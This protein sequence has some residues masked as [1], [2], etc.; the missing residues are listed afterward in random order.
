MDERIWKVV[1]SWN[2]WK[3]GPETGVPREVV[4][5]AWPFTKG[6]EAVY[7]YGPRRAGK[8]FV[9]YQILDKLSKKFGRKSCLYINFE[10][11]SFSTRLN[12][13][14]ITDIVECFTTVFGRKPK[15]IFLDE[16]QNVP[17]WEK[18]VRATV[19]KKEYK[20]FVTGS[21]AKLLSTE[22]STSLGGRGVGF[23][24]LPFSYREFR[25]A[26]PGAGFEDYLE[27]G[28]YPAV[29]L[30]ADKRKRTRL[31]E[32]YFETAIARDITG[33]Y[34]VRDVQTLKTLAVYTLTNSGK[35]FSYNKL[36]GMTGLSF[37]ALRDYLSYLEGAFMVFSAPSFSYSLKKAMQKP[38]KY[39]AYDVG[40]KSAV[41]KS[42]SRDFGRNAENSVAIELVRRGWE[43]QYYSNDYEVDFVVKEGLQLRAINVSYA[44]HP[45][46]R[47]RSSLEKF[48]SEHSMSSTLLLDKKGLEE[49]MLRTIP[50]P[51]S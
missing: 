41:S 50:F 22:F 10:E 19:D 17:Q 32:E 26:R 30:E 40:L 1:E 25:V 44:G 36:R 34:D 48:R 27:M 14:F 21:S 8:T 9:C 12:T 51:Y 33:R 28:G 37:D 15:F 4:K 24:V 2:F 13:R 3:E 16:V 35:L 43:P 20:V 46:P 5:Q 18:W 42:Y 23:M 7:F 11:P 6:P 31:L 47:E 29:V 38:R 45:P 39:Y 49:W